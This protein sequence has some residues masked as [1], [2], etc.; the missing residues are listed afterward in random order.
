VMRF[1]MPEVVRELPLDRPQ[2]AIQT[3]ASII[4]EL[5]DAPPGAAADL[6][7]IATDAVEMAMREGACLM[8]IVTPPEAAP[9]LLTGVVL[10]V[11]ASWDTGNAETLRDSMENVGGPDVRETVVMDTNLGPAVIVQRIPGVE[12][13][14]ERRPLALQLQAFV[15]EP[16]TDRMLLLTLACP[17]ADGWSSHQSL[18][19]ELVASA[20]GPA[21]KRRVVEEDESFEHHTYQ[22]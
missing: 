19:G 16:G 2:L 22:L 20:S 6:E 7:M 3:F 17:S 1:A 14:R 21:A 12:Q 8:A 4:G 5:R 9:A 18:F 10:Q 11:P 13:A 15:P